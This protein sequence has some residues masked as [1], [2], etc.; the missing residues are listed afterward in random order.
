MSTALWIAWIAAFAGLEYAGLR[1]A[2]DETYTLTNRVRK[3]MASH[4]AARMGAR[5]GITV[6]LAWLTWHF[7]GVDPV[8]NPG[9]FIA[10]F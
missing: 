3:V 8:A 9:A 5:A 7:L 10:P 4:P 1:D 2:K 6:G